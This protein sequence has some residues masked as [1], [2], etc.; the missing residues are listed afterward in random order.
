MLLRDLLSD[1]YKLSEDI[2]RGIK[3]ATDF[4]TADQFAGRIR[5][6]I[7]ACTDSLADIEAE[8]KK[9]SEMAMGQSKVCEQFEVNS[10]KNVAAQLEKRG[11]FVR[12]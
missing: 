5:H 2:A 4:I 12:R 9:M 8:K 11:S 6:A 7:F 10:W 3:E 1:L